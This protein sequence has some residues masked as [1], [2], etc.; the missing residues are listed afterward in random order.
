MRTEEYVRSC[1]VG[2]I[3]QEAV[4]LFCL[5]SGMPGSVPG[6][7]GREGV[8]DVVTHPVKRDMERRAEIL[9][10]YFK[11]ASSILT[12][13]WNEKNRPFTETSQRA[14][15]VQAISL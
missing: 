1:S 6:G 2:L 4:P 7:N 10:E 12:S 11:L 5:T 15:S 9:E 3:F 13:R 8:D 14:D